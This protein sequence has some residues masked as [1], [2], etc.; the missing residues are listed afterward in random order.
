MAARLVDADRVDAIV[1][2]H[3]QLAVV[4]AVDQPHRSVEPRVVEHPGRRA[5]SLSPP[6]LG[7]FR[8]DE[9]TGP[10]VN[11]TLE[12]GGQTIVRRDGSPGFHIGRAGSS[13]LIIDEP[14]VSRDHALLTVRR[15]KVLL[16]DMSSTGTWVAQSGDDAILLRRDVMQL[17]N[18][19]VISLGLRPKE[20]GP[21]I[22]NYRLGQEE[23]H[24]G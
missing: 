15:G 7:S 5:D 11:V 3:Q 10:K 20:N 18:D 1:V 8:A 17:S 16:T 9:P 6:D 22:I 23:G 13:D 4:A 2:M 12:F 19:G 21:T 24:D 14:C